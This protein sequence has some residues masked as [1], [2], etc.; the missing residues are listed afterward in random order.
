MKLRCVGADLNE[1]GEGAFVEV[2]VFGVMS[3]DAEDVEV[4]EVVSHLRP[5]RFE[6]TD[7][8]DVVF[9][10]EIAEAEKVASLVGIG[11]VA[12]NTGK[13]R[14]GRGIVA[15]A[16]VHK[17]DVEADAGHFRFELFGFVEKRERVIPLLTAHGDDGEIGVGRA[18]LRIYGENAAERGFG[19]VEIV[20]LQGSL[21]L[22]KPR[23]RIRVGSGSGGG[24]WLLGGE[25][26]GGKVSASRN[27]GDQEGES[28]GEKRARNPMWEELHHQVV[29]SR[30]N[31]KARGRDGT[32]EGRR[33]ESPG[34]YTQARWIL[35]LTVL[36]QCL[37]NPI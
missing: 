6:R 24:G 28:G 36:Q 32:A 31:C 17:A 16:I 34:T 11:L 7:S 29:S 9:G 21:A 22:S 15:A 26:R 30:V 35:R 5:E 25:R 20:G 4:G 13:W 33:S 14:D 37:I 1:A 19:G 12:D 3:G 18:G 2:G 8:V 27:E 10:K 23:L